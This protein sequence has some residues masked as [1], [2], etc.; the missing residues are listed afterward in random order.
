MLT[1]AF[2]QFAEYRK[3]LEALG[4]YPHAGPA[5]EQQIRLFM[6][7]EDQCRPDSRRHPV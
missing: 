2:R 7:I 1:W 6:L 4:D 3:G 5:L